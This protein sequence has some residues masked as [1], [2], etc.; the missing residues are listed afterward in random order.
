MSD[1]ATARVTR[2]KA[3]LDA[4]AKA[5]NDVR[6]AYV[7]GEPG[8]VLANYLVLQLHAMRGALEDL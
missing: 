2:A 5:M 1:H 3:A 4:A 8:E 7:E 6:R